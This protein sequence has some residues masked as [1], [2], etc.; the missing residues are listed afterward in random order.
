MDALWYLNDTMSPKMGANYPQMTESALYF[1]IAFDK[2]SGS[3]I[4]RPTYPT[5]NTMREAWNRKRALDQDS[6]LPDPLPQILRQTM[7]DTW[8]PDSIPPVDHPLILDPNDGRPQVKHIQEAYDVFYR[9]LKM[10]TVDGFMAEPPPPPDVFPNLDF[11]AIPDLGPAPGDTDNNF[12]NDVLDFVLAV[13]AL[14]AYLAEVAAY[15]AT[16]PWA[17]AADVTTYPWRLGAY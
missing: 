4:M 13:V 17:I 15:L 16:L 9:Y 10:V 3:G 7:L 2:T 8:Y 6:S 14:L 11:P 12:W 5:G 1:D